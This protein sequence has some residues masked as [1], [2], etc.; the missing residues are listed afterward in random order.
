MS[1]IENAKARFAESK[2][3]ASDLSSL[4]VERLIQITNE[5]I[6]EK[7][8]MDGKLICCLNFGSNGALKITCDSHYFENREAYTF[9]ANGDVSIA[10]WADGLISKCFA[11][12]FES[13]LDEITP[14]QQPA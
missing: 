1:H 9:Y 10:Y 12:A 4:Q 5:K 6:K 2:I 13:W 3:K 14:A 11:A 8:I 7:E